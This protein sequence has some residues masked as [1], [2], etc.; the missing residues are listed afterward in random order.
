MTLHR[1]I[2]PS[3]SPSP[4][5]AA[6]TPASRG[7]RGRL[8]LRGLAWLALLP[9]IALAVGRGDY[10]R[11]WALVLP[12]ADVGAYRVTLDRAVYRT[13]S[14]ASLD[15][16]AVYNADGGAVPAALFGPGEQLA[17]PPR[18]VALPWFALPAGDAGQARDITTI[19][20][21]DAQGRVRRVETQLGDGAP[22][23]SRVANAF[24]IDASA[25]PDRI[26][27]LD[28]DWA[29]TDAL[30]VTYDVEGSDD[31]RDWRVLQSHAPLL[32]LVR[33][34]QRLRQGRIALDTQAR[35]LRLRPTR[36]DAVLP[37]T[38]V[39]AELV[40]RNAPDD[41]QWESLAGT[42]AVVDGRAAYDFRLDGRFPV[43][44][45]DVATNGNDASTWLLQSRD[46]QDAAWIT[47][48]GPWVV[49]QLGGAQGGDRS[50]PRSLDGTVRDRYW[51]LS[52]AADSG[53]PPTLRLGYRPEV[54][55]FVARGAP[56]YALV[57]GSARSVREPAPLPQL[58]DAIRTARGPAWQ[59]ATATL[60]AS[61]AVA[62]AAALVPEQAP[63]DWKTWLLWAVL[64]LGALMVV[65]FALSLLRGA[66][67]D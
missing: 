37:L 64:V 24:L 36:L 25:V 8:A 65:G 20:E 57:A 54:L 43:G 34:G 15:D 59:P 4:P 61:T 17:Q 1:S 67:R 19:S 35:Y 16:V 53:T 40:T 51:R 38:G 31:L 2:P 7:D 66:A 29:T 47:R 14:R 12:D 28:L 60:G 5:R 45:V 58:V 56:P 23:S 33:N 21:R 50:A 39:R 46:A 62:G 6:S 41:W 26:A 42:R 30:E 32:D 27:A 63:R 11:Q 49:F 55:V 9:A 52:T 13:A 48:A 22:S 10:A 44:R 18:E 3:T